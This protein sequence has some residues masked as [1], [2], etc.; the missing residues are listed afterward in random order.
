MTN[1]FLTIKNNQASEKF[2]LIRMVPRRYAN[3]NLVS[4]GSGKYQMSFSYPIQKVMAN[5]TE[6]NLVT[7]VSIPGEYSYN[8]NTNTLT[9][10]STP[11]PSNIIIIYYYLFFTSGRHRV[12]SEDPE[13]N[14]TALRDWSPRIIQNP[15]ISSSIEN[16]TTSG[17]SVI[18]SSVELINNENEFEAYLTD[19]D[20]FHKSEVKTW[21]CLDS[22]ENIQ[23]IFDG[24]IINLNLNGNRVTI[25]F[26]DPLSLLLEPCYMGDIPDEC[27][28][29]LQN[30]PNLNPNTT[31]I[32]IPYIIGTASRYQL[33]SDT[34]ISGLVDAQKIDQSSLYNAYCVD[35]DNSISTTTNRIWGLCRVS[36]DG[37]LQFGFT[38]SN[39]DNTNP[40][41]TRLDGTLAQINK[42][43]IGDTFTV[44]YLAVDYYLRAVYVDRINNYIYTTKEA[45]ISTGAVVNSNN[46]PVIIV[47]N[48][49]NETYNCLYGRDYT[50]TITNTTNN[51]FLKITFTNNFEANHA[52]AVLD[53]GIFRVKFRVRPDMTNGKHGSVVQSLLENAG[54]TVN[55]ASISTANSSFVVNVN[56]SIPNFDEQDFDVYIK[57]IQD[58]LKSAL[59]FIT[60]NNDFE[61]EYKLFN[62]PTS[63]IEITDVDILKNDFKIEVDYKD[64]VHQI[65]SYNPHCGSS[66]DLNA[67]ATET[68]NKTKYLN[69]V[70]KVVRFRHVLENMTTKLQDIIKIRGERKAIYNF[71]TKVINL[72]NILGDD[73]KIVKNGI[74]GNLTSKEVKIISLDKSPKRTRILASDLL[75][76]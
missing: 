68:L 33:L 60:I 46:C 65:I 41:Y 19:N 50:T 75:D 36:S 55:T 31:N 69:N 59:S 37:F 51:K 35:Y 42:F 63:S 56:F 47:T 74:L 7:S 52:L 9:I 18:S 21:I 20:S 72:D 73:I 53:P 15:T 32:P 22:A 64:I 6:L 62:T 5:N 45:A 61:V 43:R 30:F 23:K 13:D 8:E 40:N 12:I 67:S 57:Y 3:D 24:R 10:F 38:P 48:E 16:V 76:L 1:N 70:N 39:I 11:G 66:E 4:I 25:T 17:L 14:N 54:L 58:I 71:S 26:D 49:S 2:C 28:F 34:S 44:T 27:Y 29:S